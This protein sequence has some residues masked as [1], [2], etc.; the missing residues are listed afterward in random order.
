MEAWWSSLHTTW[1]LVMMSEGYSTRTGPLV[2]ILCTGHDDNLTNPICMYMVCIP[3]ISCLITCLNILIHLHSTTHLK[4]TY[5]PTCPSLGWG[6]KP[7]CLDET[8]AI[9]GGIGKL[10]GQHQ[11]SRM[12][13][14]HSNCD[15]HP[16]TSATGLDTE[17]NSDKNT[18]YVSMEMHKILQ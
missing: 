11:K 12:N 5:Q 16:T 3:S 4:W 9:S 2:H 6:R 13:P 17:R 10:H 8:H 18:K 15:R 7:E 14:C 1:I